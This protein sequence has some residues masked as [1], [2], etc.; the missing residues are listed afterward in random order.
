MAVVAFPSSC[1]VLVRTCRPIRDD[2][3]R[4]GVVVITLASHL[5]GPG[6]GTYVYVRIVYEQSKGKFPRE[7]HV[8]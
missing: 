3:S 1:N 8:V 2:G 7:H 6:S 5:R 4:D